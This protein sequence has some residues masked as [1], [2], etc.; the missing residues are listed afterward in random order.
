MP[1]GGEC[2]AWRDN[3]KVEPIRS[4]V[5]AVLLVAGPAAAMTPGSNFRVCTPAGCVDHAVGTLAELAKLPEV[6]KLAGSVT[7]ISGHETNGDLTG[8]AS[9]PNLEELDLHP[10]SP[11][12]KN[13]QPLAGLK[14]L[15]KLNVQIIS[16]TDA[17][18][19]AE[20][21]NLEHLQIDDSQITRLPSLKKL[22]RLKVLRVRGAKVASLAP[23][24]DAAA[25]EDL[26]IRRTPVKSLAP[27]KGLSKL[28]IVRFTDASQVA[29]LSPL[30]GLGGIEELWLENTAVRDVA[31][32]HKLVK[33]RYLALPKGRVAPEKRKALQTALPDL[34]IDEN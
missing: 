8:I 32:L 3:G 33:L 13:L 26:E 6:A 5:L 31:A 12:F 7:S 4:L 27:L 21:V 19:V 30:A 24:A 14:A 28:R 2:N 22:T 23:V 9:F 16:L 11:S 10:A 1:V 20:L 25:L 15:R 34:K 18:A 17:S 29:D